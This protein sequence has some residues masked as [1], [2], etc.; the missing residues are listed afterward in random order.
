M[1]RACLQMLS[2]VDKRWDSENAAQVGFA[3]LK[4]TADDPANIVGA[5]IVSQ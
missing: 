1:Q 2:F 3:E 4:E 5:P